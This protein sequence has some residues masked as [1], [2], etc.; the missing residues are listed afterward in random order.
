MEGV[1]FAEETDMMIYKC[2]LLMSFWDFRKLFKKTRYFAI[3]IS[4]QNNW[5][6]EAE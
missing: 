5:K 2:L 3:K 4:Q 1:V 6:L